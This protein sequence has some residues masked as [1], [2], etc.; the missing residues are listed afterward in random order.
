VRAIRA[1]LLTGLLVLG[2]AACAGA[3]D[4]PKARLSVAEQ[5][6]QFCAYFKEHRRESRQ[7]LVGG[8][9][10]VAPAA[11]KDDLDAAHGMNEGGGFESSKRIQAYIADRCGDPAPE[12]ST[13]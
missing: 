1:T 4:E 10:D 9:L 3:D 7:Q 13:P 12:F 11:I 6:A 8:L 5:E 2:A